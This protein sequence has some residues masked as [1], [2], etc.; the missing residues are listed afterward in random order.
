MHQK[1]ALKIKVINLGTQNRQGPCDA[2]QAVY[3]VHHRESTKFIT[4]SSQL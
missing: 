4:D 3:A 2:S 1:S